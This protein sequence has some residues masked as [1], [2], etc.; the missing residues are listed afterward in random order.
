MKIGRT[1]RPAMKLRLVH[2]RGTAFDSKSPVSRLSVGRLATTDTRREEQPGLVPAN[3]T[4]YPHAVAFGR[5][6]RHDSA[7]SHG[8]VAVSSPVDNPHL[9]VA[10]LATS[11]HF[12]S[13]P[14]RPERWEALDRPLP[15]QGQAD[16]AGSGAR[17]SVGTPSEGCPPSSTSAGTQLSELPAAMRPVAARF[18]CFRGTGGAAAGMPFA[19]PPGWPQSSRR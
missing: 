2:H 14:T 19:A 5:R 11:G 7:P 6:A 8:F 17:Q 10:P 18:A 1:P 9:G 15:A 16:S 4:I 12:G 13:R 3:N